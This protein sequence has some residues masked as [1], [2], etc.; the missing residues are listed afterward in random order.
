MH[1]WA[2]CKLAEPL[3]NN[4]HPAQLCDRTMPSMYSGNLVQVLNQPSAPA[5]VLV[6]LPTVGMAFHA[7]HS[8]KRPFHSTVEDAYGAF[9]AYYDLPTIS[10]RCVC[11]KGAPG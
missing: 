10:M 9:S 11:V 2:N 8:G 5:L 3:L 1:T 6:H 4:K 7:T